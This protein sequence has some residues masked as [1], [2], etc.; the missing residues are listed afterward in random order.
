[1]LKT[2]CWS[3]AAWFAA[4]LFFGQ[5]RSMAMGIPLLFVA[6]LMQ[7]FCMRPLAS[8]RALVRGDNPPVWPRVPVPWRSM[9]SRHGRIPT[10]RTLGVHCKA[11]LP[12]KDLTRAR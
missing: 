11:T 6:G 9:V 4:I 3:A 8:T 12:P 10:G 7:S 5:T 1:M 2:H